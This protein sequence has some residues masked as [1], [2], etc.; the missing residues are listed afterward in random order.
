MDL[1]FELLILDDVYYLLPKKVNYLEYLSVI[2]VLIT[3]TENS[4]LLGFYFSL[5]CKLP[6]VVS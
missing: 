3:N 6:L 5:Y 4:T 1:T 2:E